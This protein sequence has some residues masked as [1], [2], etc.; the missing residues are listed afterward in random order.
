MVISPD[1]AT[2]LV[3][4]G[5]PPVFG[6]DGTLYVEAIEAGAGT[7]I[8]ALDENAH[9]RTTWQPVEVVPT[10]QTTIIVGG[11]DTLLVLAKEYGAAPVLVAVDAGTGAP[12][13]GFD[14]NAAAVLGPLGADAYPYYAERTPDGTVFLAISFVVTTG[15]SIPAQIVAIASDGHPRAGWPF[16][17][18]SPFLFLS[19]APDGTLW[20]GMSTAS[21]GRERL[22]V[23]SVDGVMQPG[24]PVMGPYRFHDLAFDTHGDAYFVNRPSGQ[25]WL[26]TIDRP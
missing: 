25:D 20:V 13:P 3:L 17:P 26:E 1:V 18:G 14:A 10:G 4:I 23:L 8:L 15:P 2:R 5:A 7:R 19:S 9:P 12:I 6:P 22:A 16:Q 21:S 11:D 24:W